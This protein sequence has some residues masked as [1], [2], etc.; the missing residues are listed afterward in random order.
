[1]INKNL[2]QSA[3]QKY[4]LS[5]RYNKVKWRIKS[6]ILTIYAGQSNRACKVVLKDFPLQ[7]SELGIFDTDKLTRLLAITSGD[8][9]LITTKLDLDDILY[10]NLYLVICQDM[11]IR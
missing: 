10:V 2:L 11:Q 4:Y 7:D 1:M 8:L 9:M 3:I 6:N 5:G